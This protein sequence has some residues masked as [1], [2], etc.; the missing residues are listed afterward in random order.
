MRLFFLACAAALL[1]IAAV[2]H[3]ATADLDWTSPPL[4]GDRAAE[5]RLW[6]PEDVAVL[7]AVIVLV[8]GLNGDGRPLAEDADWRQL[9]RAQDAALLG[10]SMH[11]QQGSW[12]YEAGRWSGA[13]LLHALDELGHRT[14][15]Q[16]LSS[17]PLA[18]WG[19]SAGGEFNFN[20]ACWKPARV[21]AFVANKGAYYSG[22]PNAAV[23]QL[24]GL[25]IAGQ[26]DEDARLE[27]ITSLFAENRRQ[28]ARWCLAIEPDT[29]HEVGH[30][31]ELGMV[32]LASALHAARADGT[33]PAAGVAV[34]GWVG[35]L[36]THAIRPEPD[37]PPA[38][39]GR[40]RLDSW[41]PDEGTAL[42]WKMFVD[43]T[44][45]GKKPAP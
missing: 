8:P 2:G 20:F 1:R 29:A 16:E 17:A 44:L 18:L 35:D 28:G 39:S 26:N 27:N 24:P 34:Q 13:V 40:A 36:T 43:G 38:Q 32:F 23:R 7:R 3:A 14:A 31:K 15:H 10:C 41:L 12:Y 25:W 6:V 21:L 19:H 4:G 30:T 33:P 37:A 22:Q 45:P 9:A 42:A 11:G 5:F